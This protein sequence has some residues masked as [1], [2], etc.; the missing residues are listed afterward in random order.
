MSA[1][2]QCEHQQDGPQPR[3]E[4]LAVGQV[5]MK[6]QHQN[7]QPEQVEQ[8]QLLSYRS[9]TELA[10]SPNHTITTAPGPALCS[11]SVELAGDDDKEAEELLQISR[12]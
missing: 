12:K 2:G 5:W 7:Q 11:H 3:L 9:T 1:A 8:E 10:P 4:Q 6:P